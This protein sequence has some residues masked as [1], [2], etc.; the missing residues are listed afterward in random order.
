MKTSPVAQKIM[1]EM[2]CN[3]RLNYWTVTVGKITLKEWHNRWISTR[4]RC[5]L[6]EIKCDIP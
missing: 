5:A 2:N 6:K 3:H 4:F 1:A